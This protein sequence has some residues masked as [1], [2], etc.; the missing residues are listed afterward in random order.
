MLATRILLGTMMIV[1]AAGLVALDIWGSM[2]QAGTDPQV[3]SPFWGWP[4]VATVAA[5]GVLGAVELTRMLRAGGYEPVGWWA[6]LVTV[7][8]IGIPWLTHL[9]DRGDSMTA[10]TPWGDVAPS[11]LW[12]TGGLLGTCLAVLARK[13]TAGAVQ[14]V[15]GTLLIF[16]YMGLGGAFLVRIRCLDPGPG[17]AALLLY[18]V[19]AVKSCDIGAYL[20]GRKFGQTALAPWLSPGK[21]TE[22]LAGGLVLACGV[23]AGAWLAWQHFG[24]DLLGPPP[25]IFAQALLFG[26]VMAVVGHLG[27]LVESAF[28]RDLGVK[29]SSRAVPAF[30]GVLDILD[31]PWFAAPAAWWLLTMFGRV[32]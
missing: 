12:I 6:F 1:A 30:G 3:S 14:A 2:P 5:L 10:A 7:G 22:G 16:T 8:L 20:I 27:D 13:R 11:V 25:G 29:D 9:Q 21:T 19:L 23:S 26:A 4:T 18:T 17:G 24:G 32:R 31:S 15:A 28:K